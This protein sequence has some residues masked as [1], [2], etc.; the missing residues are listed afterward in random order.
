MTPILVTGASGLIGRRVVSE[1]RAQGEAV[2]EFGGRIEDTAAVTDAVTKCRGV[3]H[4]AAVTRQAVAK[5]DPGRCYEVNVGGTQHVVDAASRVDAWVLLASTYEVYGAPSA[6]PVAESHAL[7]TTSVYGLSKAGAERVVAARGG[8]ILRLSNVYG[9]LRDHRDRVVP[10]FLRAARD[11]A[12]LR[13]F[14]RRCLDFVHRD[15]VALGIAAAVARLD[16]GAA[17][18]PVNLMGGVG[19]PLSELARLCVVACG[20][21]SPITDEICDGV[22]IGDNSLARE[23]LGWSPQVPLSDGLARMLADET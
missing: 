5:R 18:P 8:A 21:S 14:G 3:I 13:V 19:T 20:S 4:L 1:L 15:D 9:S 2:V 7:G 10:A 11:G 23:L 16:S 12:P 17:I 22:F 6:L